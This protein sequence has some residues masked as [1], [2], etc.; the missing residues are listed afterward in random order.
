MDTNELARREALGRYCDLV[1]KHGWGFRHYKEGMTSWW[2]VWNPYK[3][4]FIPAYFS[5]LQSAYE[6]QQ[7]VVEEES[8]G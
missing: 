5:S 7:A 2:R 4:D 1:D 8:V 6:H 3:N